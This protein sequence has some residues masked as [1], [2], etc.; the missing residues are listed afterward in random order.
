MLED[1]REWIKGKKKGG[2]KANLCEADLRFAPECRPGQG[3]P[4]GCGSPYQ[5]T[6]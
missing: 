5:K 1:H 4:D 3:R 6:D 2:I